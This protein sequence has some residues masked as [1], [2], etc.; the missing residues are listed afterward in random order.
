M[1]TLMFVRYSENISLNET[2]VRA[3]DSRDVPAAILEFKN[4]EM[5][6]VLMSNQPILWELNSFLFFQ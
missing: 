3:F 1:F 2:N 4:N 6:V 5:A